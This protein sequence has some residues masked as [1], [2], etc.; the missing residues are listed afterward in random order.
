MYL[1]FMQKEKSRCRSHG[2]NQQNEYSTCNK[3]YERRKNTRKEIDPISR[4]KLKLEDGLI[5]NTPVP[6]Q[7]NIDSSRIP[8]TH[9][10]NLEL[11]NI[12]QDQHNDNVDECNDEMDGLL[13]GLSEIQEI[14]SKRFQDAEN[15][16]EPVKL[17][18]EIELDSRLVECIF[19]EFQP[20]ISDIKAIKENFH[21]LANILILPLEYGSGYYWEIR[22]IHLI[23]N[24][25]KFTGC[26]MIYLGYTQREDRQ[27]QRPENL[28]VKRR[29][30]ARAPINRYSCNHQQAHEHLQYRKV[31]FPE[32][33]KQWIQNNI[34]YNLRNPELYKCLQYHELIDAQIHTK[35]QVYYWTSVFSKDTYIFN[36]ENQLLSA[37]EYLKEKLNFKTIYYL[38]NDFIKALGFTTPLL[39]RIGIT[40]LKEIIVDSTFKTNQ[41]HFELFVVNANYAYNDP[42]NQVNT[43]IQALREFFTS[44][45]N[46]GLLPT[47]VLID[48]DAGEISA[49]E[50]AWSWTVNLQLCYWHLEHAIEW[51]LK[52]KK[53]KSTG[54]S[55]NKAIEAHQQFDFIES[56]WIPTGCAGSLC[57]DDKIKEIINIVKRHAIMHSL[58][59][60]AKNT[61]WN[62]TQIY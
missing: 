25:K 22:K 55:K 61:F 49:I 34:K 9:L 12:T 6:H 62:S 8:F 56:T 26:A 16:N 50:E 29:S 4:K 40:N 58:I 31:A 10:T 23:T 27:W 57:P 60:V 53:S 13:Y 21:Q 46:E 18:F 37:K 17:T 38:E 59:P 1:L 47:F 42:K 14:I 44:L 28:P 51:H 15:L 54:Y 52:D 35:E 19:P 48:K 43:R 41:E 32:A 24:K 36:S 5:V 45:R 2:I 30:E 33:A 20:D 7:T 39:N 3:C 11:D